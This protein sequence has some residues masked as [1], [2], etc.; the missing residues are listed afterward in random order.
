MRGIDGMQEALFTTVHLETFVPQDHPLR[1][2]RILMNE[3]L[4][5]LNRLFG[6]M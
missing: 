4:K 1:G 6:E 2:I 5:E 3:A